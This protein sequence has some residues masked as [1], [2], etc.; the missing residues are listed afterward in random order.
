ME[1]YR[2]IALGFVL[3]TT[4]LLVAV[5]YASLVRAEIRIT[6]IEQSISSSFIV[7]VSAKPTTEEEVRGRVVSRDVE[8]TDTF[9]LSPSAENAAPVE[10]KSTGM[11]TIYNKRSTPQPLV[12]TTRF[13]SAEGV[14]FRLNEGVSVPANGEVTA[15]MTADQPGGSG[16]VPAGH[17]TI[18][19]LAE[20]VQALVY[21]ETTEAM[22]GG[23][24]YVNVLKQVDVDQAIQDLRDSAVEEVKGELAAEVGVFQGSVL[25]TEDVSVDVDTEVG[26]ETDGFGVKATF[27]VVGV[28][29]DENELY[30]R[31]EAS[32]YQDIDQ[33]LRPLGVNAEALRLQVDRFSVED[34]TA[35]LKVELSG[36]AIPSAAHRALSRGVFAGMTPQE[37]VAYFDENHLAKTVEVNVRP[38]WRKRLP[39]SPNKIKLLIRE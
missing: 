6:P 10:G 1:L 35:A 21:G 34:E 3:V 39:K 29:F 9:S 5:I 25:T 18:P 36:A 27:R 13:L 11:V 4:S 31:A 22:S 16:D 28:F 38:M 17:F 37:V 30:T 32:L 14:L 8:V 7:D 12:A 2:R 24:R 20:S 23:L 15:K 19:G 26:T 33:G